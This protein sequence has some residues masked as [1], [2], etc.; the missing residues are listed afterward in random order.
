MEARYQSPRRHQILRHGQADGHRQCIRG[1]QW[2]PANAWWLWLFGRLWCGKNC[3]RFARAPNF[4]RHKRNYAPDHQPPNAGRSWLACSTYRP[5]MSDILIRSSGHAGR[6]TLNR[7]QALNALTYEMA[8]QI[9]AA[10]QAWDT[11]PQIARVIID[12]TGDKAF[13]AG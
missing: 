13:C 10:L 1:G 11:D 8:M 5:G 3:A 12:A 9:D 6:I 7:P 4:G 2:L